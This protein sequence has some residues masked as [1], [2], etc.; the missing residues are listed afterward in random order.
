MSNIFINA[1]RSALAL[2]QK[3]G[4]ETLISR[5]DYPLSDNSPLTLL[6]GG[7]P[8]LT[9]PDNVDSPS[10]YNSVLTQSFA[11]LSGLYAQANQLTLAHSRSQS[12]ARRQIKNYQSQVNTLLGRTRTLQTQNIYYTDRQQLF[13]AEAIEGE[14]GP[15]YFQQNTY[16]KAQVQSRSRELLLGS[17][18]ETVQRHLGTTIEKTLGLLAPEKY[19]PERAF[20]RSDAFFWV[21]ELLA[22]APVYSALPWLSAGYA[23]GAALRLR[24]DAQ[25]R[26][27]VSELA[28][29][30][31]GENALTLLSF[32]VADP[33]A[34]LY[35]NPALTVFTGWT[36]GGT[37]ASGVGACTL[38][39]FPGG[40]ASWARTPVI[41]AGSGEAQISLYLAG[42]PGLPFEIEVTALSGSVV[43]SDEVVLGY[44]KT[45]AL[46][47]TIQSFFLPSGTTALKVKLNLPGNNQEP[48]QVLLKGIEI[49]PITFVNLNINL[50]P[51]ELSRVPLGNTYYGQNFYLTF[52]QPAYALVARAPLSFTGRPGPQRNSS[53][54]IAFLETGDDNYALQSRLSRLN[55]LAT[56]DGDALPRTY[57]QYL[58]GCQ[59]IEL[60]T[61]SYN[62]LGRWVSLPV[63]I[64]GEAKSIQLEASE[65]FITSSSEIEYRITAREEDAPETGLKIRNLLR[66]GDSAPAQINILATT[67][68]TGTYDPNTTI[69]LAPLNRVDTFDG[70]DQGGNLLLPEY[71]YVNPVRLR[72]V[73]NSLGGRAAYEPNAVTLNTVDASGNV[74]P[75]TGYCPIK[76]TLNFP[77][78]SQALP[79]ILG[80]PEPGALRYVFGEILTPS[81]GLL[82][83]TSQN[84]A[85]SVQTSSQASTSQ[86]GNQTLTTTRPAPAYSAVHQ[87]IA[88]SPGGVALTVYFSQSK[89]PASGDVLI[90]ANFLQ[91]DTALGIVTINKTPPASGYD[92]V[93]ANYYY[94]P[95]ENDTREPVGVTGTTS[96]LALTQ[97]YP[98]TRNRTPY[99]EPTVPLLRPPVLDPL[100]SNYYPVYEYYCDSE[101]T[102]HFASPLFPY[103]DNPAQVVIAYPTLAVRPRLVINMTRP[104]VTGESPS[105][106]DYQLL[107]NTRT[108]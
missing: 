42:T 97:G 92:Q 89:G 57:Y 20:S 104:P 11:D 15:G 32:G 53:G 51:G 76:V 101:G 41:T 7:R 8:T 50:L 5:E 30:P 74:L 64:S 22:D 34:T 6:P 27:H 45:N 18:G 25:A 71:P 33:G 68:V 79:D 31:Y 43:L 2:G 78:G 37:A 4:L 105:V 102:L 28:L 63:K 70:T 84:A 48:V 12:Q 108:F 72:Q 44:P 93:K 67:E 95:G 69:L 83:T 54:S 85:T 38:N 86:S 36:F 21:S 81:A 98:V 87:N 49:C 46:E 82:Q 73:Y 66:T 88:A 47:K 75:V 99:L 35:N 90:P 19:G 91:V 10:G 59:S 65:R 56:G 94:I 24:L 77:D 52:S 16:P 62:A 17:A 3:Q 61:R 103:G 14:N 26:A 60:R 40:G 39:T 106:S 1:F 55:A 29:M 23:G 80:R 13:F 96:S 58:I 100:D 9:V 107:F